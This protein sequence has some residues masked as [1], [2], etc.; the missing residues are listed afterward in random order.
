M[1]L[2]KF[3][4]NQQCV[5]INQFFNRVEGFGSFLSSFVTE[6]KCPENVYP[7]SFSS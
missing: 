2:L 5:V 4:N 3:N 1:T 6:Q 7:I